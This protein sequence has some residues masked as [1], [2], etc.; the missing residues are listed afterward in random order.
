MGKAAEGYRRIKIQREIITREEK[1]ALAALG[2]LHARGDITWQL[3]GACLEVKLYRLNYHAFEKDVYRL[4]EQKNLPRE[5]NLLTLL[6]EEITSIKSYGISSG[7]RL[8]AG[9]NIERKAVNRKKKELNRG[10]YY[11]ARD[12]GF[13]PH[14]TVPGESYT[15]KII[16]GDS[17]IILKGIPDNSVDLIFTSPPYNFGLE[18]TNTGDDLGWPSYF[19]KLFSIFTECIRVLKYGGRILVN[20][21]PL[22]SDYI[23][24]HHLISNFFLQNKLIWKGEILWEKSNYNCK[25]TAWGSWKSPSS[26]YLKYTWEFIEI[27]CKGSL[28]KEGKKEDADITGEEFKEWVYARWNISPERR[29]KEYGHPAMF[30]EK[31]AER[32]IKLFSFKGDL[33]LDPFNGVGTTTLAAKKLGRRYLGMDISGEYCDRARERVDSWP[34]PG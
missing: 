6:L 31:L 18:Y 29:M 20:V 9:Y 2:S 5:Q 11:Y 21:Q 30:P 13:L 16:C 12:P 25:Y 22:Y 24:S 1:G 26:P 19:E 34:P 28:K 33:V 8:Y 4:V 10:L 32:V 3:S 27:F 14:N 7:K 17:G 15:D 23:P